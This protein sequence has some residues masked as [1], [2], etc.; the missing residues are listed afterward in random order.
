MSKTPHQLLAEAELARKRA[1]AAIGNARRALATFDNAQAD[2][3]A[4]LA[5]LRH[6]LRDLQKALDA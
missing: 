6:R 3:D 2:A 5:A 1:D 4:A